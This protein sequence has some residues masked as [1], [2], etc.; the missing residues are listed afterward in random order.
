MSKKME[1]NSYNSGPGVSVKNITEQQALELK[2]QQTRK[3][4]KEYQQYIKDNEA[5][6]ASPD[7]VHEIFKDH[8]KKRK[9]KYDAAINPENI[10]N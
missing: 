5:N 4:E 8:R 3:K 2:E 9:E 1:N 7:E 10:Q 6:K